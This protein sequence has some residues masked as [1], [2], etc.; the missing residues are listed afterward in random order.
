MMTMKDETGD[1]RPRI[2]ENYVL[3]LT[4]FFKKM[5]T[6]PAQFLEDCDNKQL[7]RQR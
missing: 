1:L 7:L 5:H 2:K 6:S 4:Q 3:R